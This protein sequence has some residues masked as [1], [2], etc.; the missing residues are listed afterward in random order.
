M[1]KL[2]EEEQERLDKLIQ[3]MNARTRPIKVPPLIQVLQR[4]GHLSLQL[5]MTSNRNETIDFPGAEGHGKEFGAV[6]KHMYPEKSNS[7]ILDLINKNKI[8]ENSY[9]A[10]LSIYKNPH[11]SQKSK[12]EFFRGVV[13]S[14][15]RNPDLSEFFEDVSNE[16][17]SNI[18]F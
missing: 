17:Y 10:I 7:E 8:R 13:D 11:T 16:D 14:L 1:K 12:E 5:S 2:T 9:T 18:M 15:E 4:F 6:V 3:L